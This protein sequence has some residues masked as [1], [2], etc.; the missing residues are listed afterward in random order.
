M[1]KTYKIHVYRNDPYEFIETF[2]LKSN[3][4]MGVLVDAA[5]EVRQKYEDARVGKVEVLDK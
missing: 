2:T 4:Y 3:S 5:K 1:Y